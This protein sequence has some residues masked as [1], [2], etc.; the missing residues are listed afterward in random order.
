MPATDQ[1]ITAAVPYTGGDAADTGRNA[2]VEEDTETFDGLLFTAKHW[3]KED[4]EHARKWKRN[5]K[6]DYDFVAGHQWSDEDKE[7]LREQLRPEVTFNRIEPVIQSVIGIE[8][9]NRREVEYIPRSAGDEQP[10]EVLTAAAEWARDQCD[11]EDEESDA[12][13]DLVTCG[14]A[15][16]DSRMDYEENPDGKIVLERLNPLE[17]LWD[18][19]SRK[20][21]LAD[22]R[23]TWRVRTMP[24]EDARILAPGHEDEDLDASWA[25][26][27]DEKTPH[28]ADPQVAYRQ[29]IGREDRRLSRDITLVHLQWWERE[30]YYRVSVNGEMAELSEDQY[31]IVAK[32]ALTATQLGLMPPMQA[33]RMVRKI[34]KQALIGSV[35]L[36]ITP[37]AWDAGFSW[38]CLTGKRDHNAGTWYGLVRG[39]KDPQRWANKWLSQTMHILNSNAKGG[40]MAERGA[41]DDDRQAEDSIA[42]AD[43]ITWMKPGA[44][45]A[46]RITAKQP[47]PL[48]DSLWQLLNYAI[49]SIRDVSGINVE[50][51]GMREAD[52]PAALEDARKQAGMNILA[53]VFDAL[54]RY[55]K[56]QGRIML[57]FILTYLSDG[58]L[59]RIVGDDGAKYVPLIRQPGLVEYDVIVDDEATSPNQKEKVWQ[60]LM[61]MMPILGQSLDASDW[62]ILFQYSPLPASVVEKWQQKIQNDQQ[63][64]QPIQQQMQQLQM[65]VADTKAQLQAAQAQLAQAQAAK[66]GS[67]IGQQQQDNRQEPTADAQYDYMADVHRTQ[68]E[69]DTARLRIAAELQAKRERTAA[70]MRMTARKSA[71]DAATRIHDTHIRAASQLADAAIDARGDVEAARI[72]ARARNNVR[73]DDARSR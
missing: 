23:R 10:D 32:R 48:P 47:P 31:R 54:R 39:M 34:Y 62:A 13:F 43:R 2:S 30:T 18:A 17:M 26:V 25:R 7:L 11:A 20:R 40:W 41:F 55:R 53:S 49:S 70:D 37:G 1:E 73:N 38:E 59:I 5:T 35:V 15:W 60:T 63:Q 66:A 57:Y 24:I 44:I 21:N 8:I 68:T 33:A 42:R 64:Q 22:A 16:V 12:F 4:E 14:M 56:R 45:G 58:R 36:S 19:A 50:L 71:I 67:E 27:T 9:N 65:A 28:N 69:A 29:D 72:N 52:Q 51:L 3:Y 46:Q 6:E 61:Q